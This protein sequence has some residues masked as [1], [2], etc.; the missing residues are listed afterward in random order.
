MMEND[1][2]LLQQFFDTH[3]QDIADNGF[4]RH[5]IRNLPVHV[6]RI[7]RIWTALCTVACIVFI[8][9]SGALDWLLN[10]IISLYGDVAGMVLSARPG[11]FTPFLVY[12]V[13]FGI[14]GFFTY[15]VAS[16]DRLAM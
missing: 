13:V 11:L 3:R 16:S 9:V 12:G 7:G 1:D 8:F 2:K 5:V 14:V 4:S 10:R 15:K 6:N